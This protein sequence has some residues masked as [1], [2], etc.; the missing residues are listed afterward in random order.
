MGFWSEVMKIAG[1]MAKKVAVVI[2]DNLGE[3]IS[4]VATWIKENIFDLNEAPS[5]IPEKATMSET[6]KI[7]EL[8]EKCIEG[9]SK[10]SKMYD[11][12]TKD[13]V[14][15]HFQE[16]KNKLKEINKEEETPIIDNYI[17]DMFEMRVGEVKRS[18]DNI[19]SKQ[20]ANVFSLNNNK[21]L[22]IL[23]ME[24][25]P[26]K[27]K[28]LNNL[29]KRTLEKAYQTIK[30]VSKEAIDEQQ[31]FIMEKLLKYIIDRQSLS[32]TSKKE[33]ENIIDSLGKDKEERQKLEAKYDNIID[34]LDLLETL[35]R[36]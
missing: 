17:F 6:E 16:I 23:K 4:G 14:E 13:I 11:E 36:A 24:K 20:I 1:S 12:K 10:E 2:K 7:N 8:I 34:K 15:N 31:D 32:E 5:Y 19:Y 3:I 26:E 33:T 25:G 27:K 9:Y 30:K 28:E 21:L 18:L 35:M 22:N 29:A